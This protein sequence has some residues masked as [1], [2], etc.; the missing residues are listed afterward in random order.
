MT[1]QVMDYVHNYFD[2]GQPKYRGKFTVVG[3]VISYEDGDMGI[4]FGQYYKIVGS[5]FNDGVWQ[6]GSNELKDETFTGEVWLM[7]VPPKFIALVNDINGWVNKYGKVVDS[8]Y[9]SENF[10]GYSYTKAQSGSSNG[11]NPNF[12]WQAAFRTRLNAW[13]KIS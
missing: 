12:S 4:Q 11:G 5:V 13:R 6:W 7:A 3:G 9:S 8:P 10:G 1:E 2:A